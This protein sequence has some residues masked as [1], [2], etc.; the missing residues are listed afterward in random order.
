MKKD[1][2]GPVVAFAACLLLGILAAV[3]PPIA[4]FFS[5]LGIVCVSVLAAEAVSERVVL[6]SLRP[7][8]AKAV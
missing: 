3:L 8:S 4:F 5:G 6:P 7:V 2:L 1:R